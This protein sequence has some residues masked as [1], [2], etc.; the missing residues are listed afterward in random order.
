MKLERYKHIGEPGGL[1]RLRERTGEDRV[2]RTEYRSVALCDTPDIASELVRIVNTHADLLAAC[3][4]L[5][6]APHQ[7]HFAARLNDEEM[8]GILAI[9]AAIASAEAWSVDVLARRA[10]QKADDPGP[11]GPSKE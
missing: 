2:G 3:K 6:D 10:L 7:E 5:I 9:K 11:F 8:G 1:C 4:L